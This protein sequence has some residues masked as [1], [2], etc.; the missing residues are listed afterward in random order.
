MNAQNI[1]RG[2]R[3]LALVATEPLEAIVEEVV[4]GE[5]YQEWTSQYN[6][7]GSTPTTIYR[8]MVKIHW[9]KK[10]LAM[11]FKKSVWISAESVKGVIGPIAPCSADV[12]HKLL[13]SSGHKYCWNCGGGLAA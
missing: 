10:F 13:K 3:V 2:S 9:T 8:G 4:L 12:E 5:S 1:F 6:Q 7:L 11:K